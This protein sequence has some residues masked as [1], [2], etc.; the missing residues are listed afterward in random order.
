MEQSH[1]A[2]LE[3]D[4]FVRNAVNVNY[5]R[6]R[7][8][9][10]LNSG[11]HRAAFFASGKKKYIPMRIAKDEYEDFINENDLRELTVYLRE[12][13]IFELDAPIPH[14][15]FYDY[16]CSSGEF[17]YGFLYWIV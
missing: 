11:K 1:S 12:N 17:Y 9:F 4:F 16:P 13:E 15:Y 3:P 10:N 7:G 14:P 5:D 8:V 6:T 2:E